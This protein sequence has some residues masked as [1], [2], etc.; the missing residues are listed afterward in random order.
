MKGAP[1]VKDAALIGAAQAIAHH[2]QETGDR[3][4]ETGNIIV[5][6]CL[7]LTMKGGRRKFFFILHPPSLIRVSCLLVS[8]LL[9][10]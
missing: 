3:R 2:E 4:H 9:S 8:C 7:S 10:R 6:F 5:D 1:I